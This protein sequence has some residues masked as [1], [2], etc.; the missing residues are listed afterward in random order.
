M[1]A[2]PSESAFRLKGWHVLLMFLGFFGV[3]I[4]VNIGFVVMSIRTFPG[5]V[6]VTPYEDGLLHDRAVAQ[7][8]AQGRLGWSATA[9]TETG[10]VAVEF[11][12]RAGAPLS[13]LQVSGDLQRPATETGRI[14]LQF[15]ETGPGR[16]VAGH[17]ALAGA[18]DLT[19][20]A[21]D[22]Q[23]HRFEAQRRLVWP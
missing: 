9:A 12:D 15:R 14:T 5:Q 23:A 18:W 19:A 1:S 20:I 21:V 22:G 13:G 8:D 2:L 3:V 16:Y 10:A 4:A 6:S 17:A 7:F 11:R